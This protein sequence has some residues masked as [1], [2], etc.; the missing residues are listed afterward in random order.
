MDKINN[1]DATQWLTAGWFTAYQL[2]NRWN[3]LDFQLFDFLKLGL[4]AY[5]QLGQKIVDEETLPLKTDL[6]SLLSRPRKRPPMHPFDEKTWRIVEEARQK[7][8]EADIPKKREAPPPGC[9]SMNF[10]LPDDPQERKQAIREGLKLIFK[11]QDVTE[12]ENEIGITGKSTALSDHM[13]SDDN[14]EISSKSMLRKA[15]DE[16]SQLYADVSALLKKKGIQIKSADPERWFQFAEEVIETKKFKH[17]NDLPNTLKT[18]RLRTGKEKQDFIGRLLAKVGE[19]F[20]W[21]TTDSQA[22][23]KQYKRMT[24]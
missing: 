5:T 9:D 11:T 12:F 23:Y 7:A 8:R 19:R 18:N 4:T 1:S 20:D 21:G 3:I 17:I 13:A 10:N 2:L 14:P 16:A 24:A 6:S 22:L 15:G